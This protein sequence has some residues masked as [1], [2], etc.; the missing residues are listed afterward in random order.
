MLSGY[1]ITYN[2]HFY[3]DVGRKYVCSVCDIDT[4]V[5]VNICEARCYNGKN[6]DLGILHSNISHR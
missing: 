1:G 4:N 2:A 3:F 6:I 5:I